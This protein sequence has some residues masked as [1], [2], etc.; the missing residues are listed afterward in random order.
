LNG[1]S[2][3]AVSSSYHPTATGQSS[4]YAPLVRQVT[5]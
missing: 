5:G 3:S 2:L 4:G 1:L